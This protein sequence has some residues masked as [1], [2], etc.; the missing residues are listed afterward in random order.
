M[1]V[2]CIKSDRE[3]SC[4]IAMETVHAAREVNLLGV[5]DRDKLLQFITKVGHVN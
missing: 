5:R 1:F 3:K 2:F 4:L